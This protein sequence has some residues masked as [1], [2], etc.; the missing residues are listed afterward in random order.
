MGTRRHETGRR[1]PAAN[2]PGIGG[3][4]R[5][6]VKLAFTFLGGG[7][8][9]PT[10]P[11]EVDAATANFNKN[12]SFDSITADRPIDSAAAMVMMSYGVDTCEKLPAGN[13]IGGTYA[14]TSNDW[15]APDNDIAY[16]VKPM[17]AQQTTCN[18]KLAQR[19][20]DLQKHQ[21]NISYA[22]GAPEQQART[23]RITFTAQ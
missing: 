15:N 17:V 8:F 12:S 21:F 14:A 10:G 9:T 5:E 6:I 19:Q 23:P 20:Q 18:M 11:F 3:Q 16:L 7:A 4:F 1:R 2:A 22:P 13:S